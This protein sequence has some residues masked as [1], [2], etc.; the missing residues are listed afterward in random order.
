MELAQLEADAK[1]AAI[2]DIKNMLQRP[3]QLEKVDQYKHRVGR[4]KASVEA[5]LKTAMQNQL[6][7]VRV[8]FKQLESCLV[9]IKDI[10][11]KLKDVDTLIQDV[12]QIYDSLEPVREENAKHSQYATAMENLKHIFTVQSSVTKTMQWI[13]EDK[14]LHAHQ[15]R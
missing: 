15:V 3:G 4:K 12:P 1:R 2:K 6:D 8:G 5:M 14:L 11:E 13:E 10:N 9:E 7:G